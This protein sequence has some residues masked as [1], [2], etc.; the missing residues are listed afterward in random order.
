MIQDLTAKNLLVDD[1]APGGGMRLMF[2]DP[3]MAQPIPLLADP[4]RWVP[5]LLLAARFYVRC[6]G[7]AAAVQRRCSAA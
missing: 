6:S 1:G 7:G 3:A 5:C 2:A 4:M